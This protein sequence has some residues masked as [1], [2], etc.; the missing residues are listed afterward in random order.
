MA[1]WKLADLGCGGGGVAWGYAQTGQ[2]E[3]TGFD[4]VDQPRYPFRFV[5]ADM[6]TVDLDGF[7]AYHLSAPCERWAT[8]TLSQRRA[9]PERY[10]DLITPMRPRLAAAGKPYVIENVP[11]APLRADLELCGCQFGLEIPGTGQLLRLRAFELS[12]RPRLRPRVHDHHAPAISICGHGTPAWQRRL[13]GHVKVAD[14]RR[15]MGIDWLDRAALTEAVPPAYARLV[16]K[17]LAAE[18]ARRT[19]LAES[20]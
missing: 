1:K 9:D 18:L 19:T 4:L 3:I 7:D 12:W 10:P 16:G 15:V 11:Q 13:T 17:L 8:A 5:K 20:A 6:L 2:F 14:W